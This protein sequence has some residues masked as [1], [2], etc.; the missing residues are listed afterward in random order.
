[1]MQK[2][3][4]GVDEHNNNNTNTSCACSFLT[5]RQFEEASMFLPLPSGEHQELP[6]QVP[7]NFQVSKSCSWKLQAPS[8]IDFSSGKDS[9]FRVYCK[10]P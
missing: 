3:R 2:K 8:Q 9:A 7:A 1:M 10:V 4:A 6:A 5:E